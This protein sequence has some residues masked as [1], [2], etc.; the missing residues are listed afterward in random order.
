MSRQP[1]PGLNEK[2]SNGLPT[3]ATLVGSAITNS[4]K[5]QVEIVPNSQYYTVL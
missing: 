1:G 5:S 2:Q 4:G 3:T